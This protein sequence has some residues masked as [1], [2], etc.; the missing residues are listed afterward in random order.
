MQLP[1]SLFLA[2]AFLIA[3]FASARSDEIFLCVGNTVLYVDDSNRACLRD[4]PCV[5]AW[6]ERE[7]KQRTAAHSCVDDRASSS[8]QPDE[9]APISCLPG[10]AR[11]LIVQ[12]TKS[13]GIEFSLPLDGSLSDATDEETITEG[14]QSSWQRAPDGGAAPATGGPRTVHVRAYYRKDGTYVRSHYRS[15]P[16]SGRSRR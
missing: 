7:A 5:R 8:R 9:H 2:L 3:T 1:R 10:P 4:H 15:P 13:G 11:D 12:T 16:G 6:F 14:R